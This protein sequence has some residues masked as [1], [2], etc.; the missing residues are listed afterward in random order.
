M[1]KKI[2]IL[3]LI[4]MRKGSKG[5]KG[6][7]IKIMNGKPL[8]AYTI[9]RAIESN[10]FSEIVVSTDSKKISNISKKYGAKCWFLRPKFLSLNNVDKLHVRRHALIESE[11]Y[12]DKKFDIIFDLDATSPLR[13]KKDIINAFDQ[14]KNENAENLISVYKSKKNPY[15]NMV[16]LSKIGIKLVKKPTKTVT[17]RQKAPIVY[18]MNASIFIWKRNSLLKKNSLFTNKTSIYTMPEN[19]SI[20]IDSEFDWEIVKYLLNKKKGKSY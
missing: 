1:A 12:F 7:N 2:N 6:K 5:V 4:C 11:K 9:E 20:D 16:E 18:D 14:F 10:I 19:R 3:C 17:S 8:A 15:F 13:N